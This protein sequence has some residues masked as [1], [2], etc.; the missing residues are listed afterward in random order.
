[1]L[2]WLRVLLPALLCCGGAVA[3]EWIS[4]F[5]GKTLKGWTEAGFDGRGAVAV[6]DG[7]IVIGKGR[8]TGITYTGSFPKSGYEIRFEAVRME[9]NDYFAG[10][11]F[12]VKDT[13]CTWVNGGWDGTVSGLSNLDGDDAS[14]NDTSINRDFVKGRWYRFRLEVTENRIRGWLDDALLIETE[15]KGRRVGLRE[16]EMELNTPLGFSTYKTI[17]GLRNVEYRLLDAI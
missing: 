5:D 16:F 6:K 15:L 7:V 10:I 12:P 1:M 8:M 14:E 9:G 13:F 11:T 2:H 4:L 3:G 17:A